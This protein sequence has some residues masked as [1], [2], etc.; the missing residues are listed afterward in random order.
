M[1]NFTKIAA[2]TTV[3][4]ASLIS[5]V[6]MADEAS[7]T[8]NAY[9]GLQA[10]LTLECSKVSFGV[11]RVPVRTGQ[12]EGSVTTIT[13]DAAEDTVT[14][15]G[16]TTEVAQSSNPAWT[17]SKGVCTLSG[18][19][20]LEDGTASIEIANGD[21][22]AMVPATPEETGYTDLI[23]VVTPAVMTATL[24]APTRTN[25]I[26]AGAVTF[27]VGGVLTIPANILSTNYGGYKTTNAATVT[28][29]DTAAE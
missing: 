21:D 25:A 14:A 5:S 6:A 9:A 16:A 29:N 10:A 3:L 23:A 26:V 13:L 4:A 22:M 27:N 15:G 7:D 28:V 17:E 12:S 19:T 24:T 20:A 8:V 18:S 2:A 1:K 11:W